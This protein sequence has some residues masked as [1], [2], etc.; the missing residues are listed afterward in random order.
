M[1]LLRRLS[2]LM[3]TSF[4]LLFPSLCSAPVGWWSDFDPWPAGVAC[5]VVRVCVCVCMRVCVCLCV[6]VC[7]CVCV[8]VC[9]CV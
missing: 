3:V 6:C 1:G 2:M 5:G 7:V 4:L 8:H 9:V